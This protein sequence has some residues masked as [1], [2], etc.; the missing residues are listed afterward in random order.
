M[1]NGSYVREH[2]DAIRSNTCGRMDKYPTVPLFFKFLLISPNKQ[3]NTDT[4]THTHT[5]THLNGCSM[6][7]ACYNF[8]LVAHILLLLLLQGR[9]HLFCRALTNLEEGA[10]NGSWVWGFIINIIMVKLQTGLLYM[11]Q[12]ALKGT[13]HGEFKRVK[14]KSTCVHGCKNLGG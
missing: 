11:T 7:N 9:Y 10:R 2:S 3:T 8:S 13:H 6:D 1:E 4:H 12:D 14:N 5:H